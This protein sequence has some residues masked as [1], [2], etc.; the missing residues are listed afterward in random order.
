MFAVPVTVIF[1]SFLTILGVVLPQLRKTSDLKDQLKIN[2]EKLSSLRI[3][4]A[5]LEGIDEA[6]LSERVTFSLAALPGEKEIMK[7]IS[8]FNGLAQ[9]TQ[10]HID[11]LDVSPGELASESAAVVN[12]NLENLSFKMKV[13]T[14]D[15]QSMVD[16]LTQVE[17]SLPLLNLSFFR[18]NNTEGESQAQITIISYFSPP[19]SN[20]GKI[21]TPVKKVTKE[22]ERLI[23]SI[24]DYKKYQVSFIEVPVATGTS[25]FRTDPFSN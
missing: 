19:P 4:L 7:I 20:L 25:S 1:F 6:V 2:K 21:D 22:D 9:I 14:P 13:T 8:L 3:K 10:V 24:R 17:Q 15:R 12:P 23:E 5:D 11:S 16:F 18:I